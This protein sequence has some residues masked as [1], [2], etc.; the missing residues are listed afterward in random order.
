MLDSKSYNSEELLTLERS[1]V[2]ALPFLPL[3]GVNTVAA[4][5]S[6]VAVENVKRNIKLGLPRLH[7][8]VDFMKPKGLNKKIALVGGGPSLKNYLNELREFKTIICCGS[9]HDYLIE[10]NIIPTYSVIC[11]PDPVGINYY[12]NLDTEVKYLVASSAHENIMNH[13]N[14]KQVVLWHCHSDDYMNKEITGVDKLE[15]NYQ[16]IGGGCTVGLRCLSM[17]LMFGYNNIHLFGFDSCLGT[18]ENNKFKPYVYELSTELEKDQGRVFPIKIGGLNTPDPKVYYCV[19]YHLAQAEHFRTFCVSYFEYMALTFHGESLLGDIYKL[20]KNK[21]REV[22]PEG[23]NQFDMAI[24][25]VFDT[26]T[27]IN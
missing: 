15:D 10:N 12:K 25:C 17:A 23:A 1:K 9:P 3:A 16:A 20:Q 6:V 4:T 11:D 19:G 27:R 13:F 22:N 2:E 8:L 18:D 24:K 14:G 5:S 26:K 7:Q 21:Y